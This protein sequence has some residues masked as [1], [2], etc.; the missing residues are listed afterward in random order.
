M[1]PKYF[2]VVK[3]PRRLGFHDALA[4]PDL[5][6]T[7]VTARFL[8]ALPDLF[9]TVLG[10]HFT[11]PLTPEFFKW[12][13]SKMQDGDPDSEISW[14]CLISSRVR[15]EYL[16]RMSMIGKL[17]LC[18]RGF[19]FWV[20]KFWVK[21]LWFMHP[22][23]VET[24]LETYWTKTGMLVHTHRVRVDI[25]MFSLSDDLQVLHTW[26]DW[27]KEPVYLAK[28]P[29]PQH[30]SGVKLARKVDTLY[31]ALLQLLCH[32]TCFDNGYS[33][34]GSVKSF[35]ALRYYFDSIQHRSLRSS[36]QHLQEL[37]LDLMPH[38]GGYGFEGTGPAPICLPSL[39]YLTVTTP[40]QLEPLH[41]S[42][43]WDLL[44]LYHFICHGFRNDGEPGLLEMFEGNGANIEHLTLDGHFAIPEDYLD[45]NN[46]CPKLQSFE[47]QINDLSV[48]PQFHGGIEEIYIHALWSFYVDSSHRRH[49][50]KFIDAICLNRA[51]WKRLV[52]I[53]EMTQPNQVSRL[54][55]SHIKVGRKM[56]MVAC[57]RDHSI[58]ILD[59][60]G[61]DKVF[62]WED[63]R[64]TLG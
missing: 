45:L 5:R 34:Y 33:G 63:T 28:M 37:T 47:I 10:P 39:H 30:K 8:S 11:P 55:E 29:E 24:F 26:D 16:S 35:P 56:Q 6:D 31:T 22:R 40:G 9:D 59:C 13:V 54:F 53:T 12:V 62:D 32:L 15:Q 23:Q 36:L 44:S 27:P 25:P 19:K 64:M 57:I 4:G 61:D 7:G 18:S 43:H 14:G 50:T 3:C 52:S 1:P 51:K 42:K 20:G 38:V 60:K 2:P 41:L 58:Q 48:F 46:L 21:D 17:H 49:L